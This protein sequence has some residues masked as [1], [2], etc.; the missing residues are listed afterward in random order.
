MFVKNRPK[1]KVNLFNFTISTFS[2]MS[3]KR[4]NFTFRD[5]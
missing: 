1:V 2:D 3:H 4:Q 5:S